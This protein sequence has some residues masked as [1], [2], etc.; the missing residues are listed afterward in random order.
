MLG[1]IRADEDPIQVCEP[2]AQLSCRCPTYQ[3]ATNA[4]STSH[5]QLELRIY[6]FVNLMDAAFGRTCGENEVHWFILHKNGQ[7]GVTVPHLHGGLETLGVHVMVRAKEK[8]EKSATQCC[9]P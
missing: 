5:P 4:H 3:T 8:E 9:A 7:H 2:P 1:Q 6:R